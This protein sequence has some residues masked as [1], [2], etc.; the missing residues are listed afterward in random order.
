MYSHTKI[1]I[2]EEESA[3]CRKVVDAF[4]EFYELEEIFVIDAG[5]YGFVKLL[6]YS[7]YNGFET[8]KTYTSSRN[9]FDD[10]WSDWLDYQFYMMLSNTLADQLSSKEI[11]DSLPQ[12]IQ[13][14]L[15]EKRCYF[16]ERAEIRIV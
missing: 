3:K 1:Y 6:Y 8:M 7:E 11:F 10:L 13:K 2:S 12:I 15:M 5:R 9:L 14:E 4:I 16:E